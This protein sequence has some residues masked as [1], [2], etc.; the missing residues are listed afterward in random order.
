MSE[1]F[2]SLMIKNIMSSNHY[3]T[4]YQRLYDLT[5][6]RL[7]ME[8]FDVVS[9][10]DNLI[11][12]RETY[13]EY[14]KDIVKRYDKK[15]HKRFIKELKKSEKQQSESTV[16]NILEI[17]NGYTDRDMI[18][19]SIIDADYYETQYEKMKIVNM[20]QLFFDRNNLEVFMNGSVSQKEYEVYFRDTIKENNPQWDEEIMKEYKN[21]N[22]ENYES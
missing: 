4:K 2:V 7:I 8:K 19:E 15:K 1:D 16:I 5:T 11:L 20:L 9:Y 12:D 18:F 13:N 17:D 3:E 21:N 10:L 14:F 6:F 22:G